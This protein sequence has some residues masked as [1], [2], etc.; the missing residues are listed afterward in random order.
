[1]LPYGKDYLKALS[2]PKTVSVG[3]NV[4]KL[5][6]E[7]RGYGNG[8]RAIVSIGKGRNGHAFNA[9]NVRGKSNTWAPRRT[10][11]IAV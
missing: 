9:E 8:A 3:T 6:S 1:M 11:A 10:S 7:M 4:K 5:E 2:N